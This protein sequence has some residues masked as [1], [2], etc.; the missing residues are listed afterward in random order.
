[1][2]FYQSLFYASP[3]FSTS[4]P[5]TSATLHRGRAARHDRQPPRTAHLRAHPQAYETT[6]PKI[7]V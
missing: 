3:I 7:D 5:L 1:M 2:E 4:G 6:E